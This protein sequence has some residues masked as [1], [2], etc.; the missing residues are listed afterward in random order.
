MTKKVSDINSE[1]SKKQINLR[2]K[3][4]ARRPR[5]L[6]KKHHF[7]SAKKSPINDMADL[8]GG[9]KLSFIYV[10]AEKH[11]PP[12][13]LGN[14]LRVTIFGI[15]MIII[16]NSIN[17]YFKSKTLAQDVVT[18]TAEGYSFL[19][20]AG[21]SA[22]Q[23]E[24]ENAISAFDKASESF[25]SAQGDLWFISTD[26]TFYSKDGSLKQ[27]ATALLNGGKHF[28]EAGKYFLAAV[29][30]YNKIPLYFVAKNQNPDKRT[31]S[32]T[33]PL[34][35]GLQKTDL[36]IQEIEKATKE[37]EGLD[38][39]T[40]PISV[41]T[42]A[43][44]AKQSLEEVTKTLKSTAEHFPALLKLL[45][46]RYP[47]RI[48]VLL[49]NNNEI[50]AT[51]GFIGSYAIIDLNDGYIEKLEVH[52]VY[53]ID[54]SFGEII[55]P[56]EEFLPFTKNWRFRDSNYSP[57]FPTSAAKAMW[58][59]QK[60]G[61][62]G[63]DTVIAINQ[64]LLRDL[65]EITGPVQVGNFG[66][67][68][69]SNYNLL[70]SFVIEGKVW[71]AENPKHILKVFVPAF[72]DA[73]LKEENVGKLTSKLY[74]AIQQKHIMM[75]SAHEDIQAL[76]DSLNV[77]GRLHE[78]RE[79]EDYLSVVNI[80]VGGTKSEQFMDENIDHKTSIS[81]SGTL[82]NEITVKRTHLWT[83]QV[84]LDWKRVLNR[85]GFSDLP[86]PIIDIL[87]RGKN[88][89]IT[90]VYVP[91]DSKIIDSK[92]TNTIQ[93]KY[94]PD[95]DRTYFTTRMQTSAGETSE[96]K[97]TYTLP[98]SLSFSPADTYRLTIDKQPGSSGSI[99]NKLIEI[100]SEIKNI[101]TFPSEAEITSSSI[102][103]STNLVYD[104]YFA[105]AFTQD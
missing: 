24:F 14:I 51:G 80:A 38:P 103:Y 8:K 81:S 26:K 87:G 33:E 65:L 77:S 47:H 91:K 63:V 84:Y 78:I 75:Y 59:M 44:F 49:Q 101:G 19:I 89:V 41:R 54:G 36:A 28:A 3:N 73:I 70:L 35:I 30:E 85:Y 39:D 15:L 58:F 45:G 55:P 97:I 98:F 29:E 25:G 2:P 79:K 93:T 17:I 74:R 83:D 42:R 21:K 76:F 82:T 46:D 22:S 57:D 90:R 56:P 31:L 50:R 64:G 69:S 105:A 66:K 100:D 52:D 104:K 32:I 12:K 9:E 13:F 4:Q 27:A 99:L 62:A 20:D 40:L 60:Q 1:N 48:L 102:E 61:G 96:L 92:S 67:L 5:K 18:K 68:D 53:D 94:D 7:F 37:M 23:I 11:N 88:D 34:K 6:I 95:T 86:D 71:G 10:K 16:I 43:I 72:K